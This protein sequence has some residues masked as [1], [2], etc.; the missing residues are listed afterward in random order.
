[1]VYAKYVE[2]NRSYHRYSSK[3]QKVPTPKCIC[4]YNGRAEQPERQVLK[5]SDAFGGDADI[6]VVEAIKEQIL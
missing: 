1:M 6:E 2:E 4:F 3:Q 5:L